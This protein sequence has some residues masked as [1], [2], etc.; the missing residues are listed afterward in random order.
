MQRLFALIGLAILVA[1]T[2][3][4]FRRSTRT[5]VTYPIQ[6]AYP[7]PAYSQPCA[8]GMPAPLTSEPVLSAPPIV[9]AP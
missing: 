4:C 6:P 9:A 1:A 5:T 2:S 3:G 7:A 8:P